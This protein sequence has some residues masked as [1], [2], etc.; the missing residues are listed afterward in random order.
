LTH[1]EN[2]DPLGSLFG[3][4]TDIS[5]P[6]HE[7]NH[8]SPTRRETLSSERPFPTRRELRAQREAEARGLSRQPAAKPAVHEAPAVPAA[9]AEVVAAS[10]EFDALL[11]GAI[12]PASVAAPAIAAEPMVAEPVVDV[13]V[14]IVRTV[15]VETGPV[16]LVATVPE[17]LTAQRE[18]P[19]SF[20]APIARRRTV[21]AE[22]L[23]REDVRQVE[24]RRL[25]RAA[26]GTSRPAA[27]P[28]RGRSIRQRITATGTMLVVGGIF[29]S[30]T[31]PAYA[32]QDESA[33]VSN[34]KQSAAQSLSVTGGQAQAVSRDAFAVTSAADLRTQYSDALRQKNMQAYLTSGARQLGD[35]YPWATELTRGEGGGLSP[36]RY[37]YRECVDFVAWRLNRD[38]GSTTAPYKWDWSTLTPG[39]GNASGW[40]SA[41][42][43]HGWAT[44]TTPQV[45]SVAWFGGQN[46][47]S[48][49]SGVLG[50]GSVVLEE[51]NWNNNHIYD[52]R[53]V[54]PSDVTLFLYAPPK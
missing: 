15:E 20:A 51:Y 52:Q 16:E 31:L 23:I 6:E 29:A 18:L 43:S 37:Y 30:L 25:I 19:A 36:L 38:A 49:V 46:H 27:D 54:K 40:K 44:G 2:P 4:L 48:Y 39:N 14:P 9:P 47:V 21:T 32:F 35:D 3:E 24:R 1:Q 22:D 53:I 34:A 45:G 26:R 41:W 5:A 10:S 7:T 17:T 28:A 8:P 12:D 33:T 50:D 42:E 13:A 11:H